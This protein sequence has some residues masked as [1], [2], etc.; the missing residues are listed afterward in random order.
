MNRIKA[1]TSADKNA[2]MSAHNRWNSIAKPLG[3]LGLL[4]LAIEKNRGGAGYGKC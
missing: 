4:E 2:E 1:I 3:S